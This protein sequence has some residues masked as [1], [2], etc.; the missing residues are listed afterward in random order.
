[1]DNLASPITKIDIAAPIWACGDVILS[2]ARR[3][4]MRELVAILQSR[5]LQ[6][7]PGDGGHSRGVAFHGSVKVWLRKFFSN[8]P[9]VSVKLQQGLRSAQ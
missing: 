8:A 4:R 6:R 7:S 3:V 5:V 1:M 9:T 2:L